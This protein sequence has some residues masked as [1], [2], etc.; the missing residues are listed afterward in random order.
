MFVKDD[1]SKNIFY[2]LNFQVLH[3]HPNSILKDRV[4]SDPNF[5]ELSKLIH[6]ASVVSIQR[7]N[8]QNNRAL[9]KA[10]F[11]LVSHICLGKS[12]YYFR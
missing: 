11:S 4:D 9:D 2:N 8:K 1:Q 12:K 3:P 7:T 5:Q 10:A 6:S